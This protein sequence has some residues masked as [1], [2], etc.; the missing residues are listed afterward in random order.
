MREVLS[1]PRNRQKCKARC[2]AVRK[3]RSDSEYDCDESENVIEGVHLFS[4]AL[5]QDA[6][7]VQKK[8]SS[9]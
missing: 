4:P 8:L 9:V 1:L 7:F 2:R 5:C 3:G 6:D